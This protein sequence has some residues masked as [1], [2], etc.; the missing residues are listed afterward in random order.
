MTLRVTLKRGERLYIGGC[1]IRDESQNIVLLIE[2]KLPLLR[3]RDLLTAN[4]ADTPAKKLALVLQQMYLTETFAE[5]HEVY[6]VFARDLLKALPEGASFVNS[7]DQH[8]AS[9]NYFRAL[10]EAR[11]LVEFEGER[12]Q[13]A[14]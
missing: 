3:E 10:K 7:V 5:L 12:S 4:T 1:A 2:G 11:D 9:G 6:I 8:I 13:A 14:A